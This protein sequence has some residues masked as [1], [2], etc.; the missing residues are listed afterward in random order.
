M[1]FGYQIEGDLSYRDNELSY[2]KK[3]LNDYIWK[4]WEEVAV[5]TWILLLYAHWEWFCKKTSNTY[6]KAIKKAWITIDKVNSKFLINHFL[7]KNFNFL[8]YIKAFIV[9]SILGR[10]IKIKY[11]NISISTENNLKYTTFKNQILEKICINQRE[12][13]TQFN[14]IM[15]KTELSKLDF[16]EK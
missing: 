2:L 13:E 16:F 14:N 9:K 12:I 3:T 4:D 15:P 7:E 5:K 1:S 8:N 10:F 6:I 11:L